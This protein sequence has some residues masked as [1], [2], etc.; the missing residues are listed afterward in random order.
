MVVDTPLGGSWTKQTLPL[1]LLYLEHSPLKLHTL[2][3]PTYPLQTQ[4]LLVCPLF[5]TIIQFTF[6]TFS[7]HSPVSAE[8]PP[9]NGQ[10]FLHL[11]LSTL[12]HLTDF[13]AFVL[14]TTH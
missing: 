6:L 3:L 11:L 5:H 14:V 1:H 10:T 9:K 2:D 7:I 12:P 4:A 8:L 13:E